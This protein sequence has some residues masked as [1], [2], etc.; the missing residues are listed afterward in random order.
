MIYEI[1]L[2]QRATVDIEDICRYLSQFY[3]GTAGRFL[4][5]LEQGLDGLMQNP[6]MY[7]EYEG[8]RNYRRMVIQTDLSPHYLVF[9]KIPK[10]GG[11]IKVYRVL[12]GKRNIEKFLA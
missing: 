9:Y 6:Y 7:V 3:P 2:L 12:H 5:A 4:D 11:T 10:T 1:K 8:N